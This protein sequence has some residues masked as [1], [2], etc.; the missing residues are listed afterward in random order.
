MVFFVDFIAR[1][2][3]WG[4]TAGA[5]FWVLYGLGAIAGPFAA[6]WL[7]DRIGFGRALSIALALQLVGVLIPS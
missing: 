3:G 5:A 4:V 1:G 6:G 2:L 7:G